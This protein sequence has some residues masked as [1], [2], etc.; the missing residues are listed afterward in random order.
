VDRSSASKRDGV[1]AASTQS[2]PSQVPATATATAPGG[3]GTIAPVGAALHEPSGRAA[4]GLTLTL[5]TVVMWSILPLGLNLALTGMDAITL[6]W[7]R[8]VAAG[9]LLWFGLF[10][11]GALPDLRGLSGN[12][13]GLLAIAT[14]ALSANYLL[15]VLG[16]ERTNAGTAQVVIQVAPMLLALGSVVL[17]KERVGPAQWIGLLVLA[18]GL[19]VF[20]RDQV[21]ALMGTLDRYYAGV[22][23]MIAAA[24]SW[25][26]YGMAQKQLLRSMPSL[27]I[28]LCIFVGAAMLYTPVA[29]PTALLSLNTTQACALVFCIVNMVIAYGTFAEAL[30]HWDAS[31][32]SAVLALVPLV[33]LAVI[34]VGSGIVPELI[35]AEPLGAVGVLGACLVVAGS[36]LMALGR[37]RP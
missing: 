3:G 25:A 23:C 7:C 8:F 28:M 11:R 37:S 6:S 35:A 19:I 27:S 10:L 18:I 1:T 16:L 24:V 13:R 12:G 33:T 34:H 32:V 15:Y 4:L 21:A 36:L 26:I 14:I 9:A 22:G 30:A 17:F 2:S 31:R 29:S 5:I 20:S